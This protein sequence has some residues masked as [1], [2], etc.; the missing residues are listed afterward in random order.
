[1]IFICISHGKEKAVE[2][3]APRRISQF[4]E[5][6]VFRRQAIGNRGKKPK[7]PPPPELTS[8]SHIKRKYTMIST[9]RYD[10]RNFC[11]ELISN[12]TT[13][14]S[15]ILAK[16]HMYFYPHQ[17]LHLLHLSILRHMMKRRKMRH[18][19]SFLA[20]NIIYPIGSMI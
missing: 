20:M 7:G 17:L 1:M 18:G 3:E 8:P 11:A 19:K 15:I 12:K 14:Y 9:T 16:A 5:M 6:P 13:N 10:N 4:F 2:K